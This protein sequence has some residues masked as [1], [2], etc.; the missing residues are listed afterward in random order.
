MIVTPI[1]GEGPLLA[2]FVAE[3]D[4]VA[5]CRHFP[6]TSGFSRLPNRSLGYTWGYFEQGSSG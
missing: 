1:F 6:R 5:G 3:A 2:D 4:C